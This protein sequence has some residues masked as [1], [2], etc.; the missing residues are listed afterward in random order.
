MWLVYLILTLDSVLNAVIPFTVLAGL[1]WLATF[2]MS[3]V[4]TAQQNQSHPD[5]D[6]D[7]RKVIDKI[8][9]ICLSIFIPCLFIAIFIPN[10][11]QLAVIYTAGNAIEYVQGNEK[12][13][14]LPDKAVQC[15]DKF[16]DDYLNEK[17]E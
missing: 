13:K 15:L 6:K 9:N 11:K 7:D 17:N 2:I 5:F 8:K 1:G 16:I 4:A 14:E 12:I 10:S 3:C